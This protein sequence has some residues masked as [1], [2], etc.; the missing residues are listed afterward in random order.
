MSYHGELFLGAA[1]EETL[2][3]HEASRAAFERAASLYPPAQSP[4]LALS[5]LAR[6]RRDRVGALQALQ[7]VFALPATV[8]ARHD[9][10]WT[11]HLVQARNADALLDD[12]RR[13]FRASITP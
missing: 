10:W 4:W 3:N 8:T 1:E 12:L 2:A 6:R 13:P 11:Y 5:Q 9:P 7:R